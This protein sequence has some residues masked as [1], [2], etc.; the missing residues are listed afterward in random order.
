MIISTTGKKS[1][2]VTINVAEANAL[3]Y[4]SGKTEEEFHKMAL[5]IV[6]NVLELYK[7][8]ATYNITFSELSF[9]RVRCVDTNGDTCAEYTCNFKILA[10]GMELLESLMYL[11]S[12]CDA[13][14]DSVRLQEF[15][16]SISDDVRNDA[17]KEAVQGAYSAAKFESD[18]LLTYMGKDPVSIEKVEVVE[19]GGYQR[20]TNLELPDISSDNRRTLLN[21][22]PA[23]ISAKETICR[24]VTLVVSC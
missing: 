10:E 2:D 22:L 23:V 5:G 15:N 6:D 20:G 3:V 24:E 18:C 14:E 4:V 21:N 11:A 8:F 12:A 7:E 16:I 13:F 19:K 9:N 17:I 1:V